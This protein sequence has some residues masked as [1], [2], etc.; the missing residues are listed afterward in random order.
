LD[1]KRHW[2]I[3]ASCGLAVVGL[4]VVTIIASMLSGYQI[5][6]VI[7]GFVILALAG[8][9]TFNGNVGMVRIVLAFTSLLFSL[10][11]LGCILTRTLVEQLPLQLLAFI[12][13]LFSFETMTLI[14]EHRRLHMGTNI[15]NNALTVMSWKIVQRRMTW[16]AIVFSGCYVLT[17][18][19]IYVG[20][21]V[22]S[23]VPFLGD[24]SV[25]LVAATV[26][27]ALLVTF[28]EDLT[29]RDNSVA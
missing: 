26:S 22:H 18:C 12:L 9:A 20:V 10:S 27:L 28:R 4:A 1:D 19:A 6:G 13:I 24:A 23:I 8:H 29:M 3:L 21:Y 11:L 7:A 16:L 5:I 25:Y 2:S 14:V 15:S 17:I